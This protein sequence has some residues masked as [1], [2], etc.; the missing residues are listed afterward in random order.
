MLISFGAAG[1]AQTKLVFAVGPDA[2]APTAYSTVIA[3]ERAPGNDGGYSGR[4]HDVGVLPLDKPFSNVQIVKLGAVGDELLNQQFVGVGYGRS[5]NGSEL[6][7]RRLGALTLKARAGKTYEF[8]FGNFEAFYRDYTGDSIPASCVAP[9]NPEMPAPA[10]LPGGDPC[11]AF[12]ALRQLYDS[13]LL[14]QAHELAVGSAPGDA[15]PCFGDSGGPLLKAGANGELLAYG[16]ASGGTSSDDLI[17][18]HGAVY[19]SFGPEVTTF[20]QQATAW[21]DPCDKL[22]ARGVCE[23]TR[24]RR[25]STAAEGPRRVVEVDCAN[26]GLRCVMTGEGSTATCGS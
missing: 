20:L 3:V 16:V 26:A 8:L 14:E 4:G 2:T 5:D 22:P 18:D 23:G 7:K 24:A 9:A 10:P 1:R 17:C 19:A 13:T 25:C 15:Q 21:T 6:T 11:A 12:K